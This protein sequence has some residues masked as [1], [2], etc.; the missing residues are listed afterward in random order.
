MCIYFPW[1]QLTEQIQQAIGIRQM[2]Q[3]HDG[4]SFFKTTVKATSGSPRELSRWSTRA[5]CLQQPEPDF[6]WL[7]GLLISR[8][9]LHPAVYF[10]SLPGQEG[11]PCFRFLVT[12]SS[13]ICGN[14]MANLANSEEEI[15]KTLA[16]VC[17]V[18]SITLDGEK[19][20]KE[21]VA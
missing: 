19:L 7:R 16:S 17:P 1:S 21:L 13:G 5:H 4:W 11:R 15:P 10:P 14:E 8:R 2:L 3:K 18:D 9:E 6:H 12:P 20:N